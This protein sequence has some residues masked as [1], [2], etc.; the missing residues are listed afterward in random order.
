MVGVKRQLVYEHV[1]TSENSELVAVKVTCK[2]NS[3]IVASFY[4]TTNNDLDHNVNL[5]TAMESLV[6]RYPN[7]VIWTGGD[8]NLLDINWPLNT[9]SGNN[10]KKEINVTFLQAVEN[11]GLDQVVDYQTRDDNSLDIFLTNR[12]SLIQTCKSLA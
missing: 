10:Y 7:E 6:K 11:S 3:V 8:A 12:P 2:H 9:V 4:R 1:P 5:T